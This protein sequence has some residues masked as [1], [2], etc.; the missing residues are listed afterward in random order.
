MIQ[1]IHILALSQPGFVQQQV[2]FLFCGGEC[3]Q[4]RTSFWR[5]WSFPEP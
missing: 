5:G 4:R 3:E 1:P 2:R